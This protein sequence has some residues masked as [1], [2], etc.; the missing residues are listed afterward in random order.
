[1]DKGGMVWE[2]GDGRDGVGGRGW[3]GGDGRE[4]MRG[5]GWEGWDGREWMSGS[6]RGTAPRMVVWEGENI[7]NIQN[8]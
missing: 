8:K 7:I 3:E 4:G 6:E 2:G 5:R 1:M